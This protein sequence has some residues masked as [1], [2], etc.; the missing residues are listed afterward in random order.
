MI[1]RRILFRILI[2]TLLLSVSCSPVAYDV[3]IEVLTPPASELNFKKVP[4]TILC[5]AGRQNADTLIYNRISEGMAVSIEKNLGLLHGA[6]SVR[7]GFSDETSLG[8]SSAIARLISSSGSDRVAVLHSGDIGSYIIKTSDTRVNYDYYYVYPT[9]VSIPYSID[10]DFY[11][12]DHLFTGDISPE[13]SLSI[14]DTLRFTY[15]SERNKNDSRVVNEVNT[16]M[17]DAIKEV[18]QNIGALFF[19]SWT[20]QYRTVASFDGITD[21]EAAYQYAT[22]FKWETALD[23]WIKL[24]QS[25]N[26]RKSGLAAYNA[27]V[28]CEMLDEYDLA[29][30]WLDIA[31]DKYDFQ[32]IP[33]ERRNILD[34]I[35]RASVHNLYYVK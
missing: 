25:K 4:P 14:R 3:A 8:D 27:A 17:P 20:E 29:L 7:A 12:F 32:C 2:L 30:E 15:L 35:K 16:Q 34:A 31:G 10:I 23:I 18:G 5:I 6:V 11:S 9:Y 33:R 21:W 19:P 22:E 13:F 24:A 28:A 1:F 26:L